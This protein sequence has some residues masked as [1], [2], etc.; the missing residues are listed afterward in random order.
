MGRSLWAVGCGQWAVGVKSRLLLLVCRVCRL[1]QLFL[2]DMGRVGDFD[3]AS[4]GRV[5]SVAGDFV[6]ERHCGDRNEKRLILRV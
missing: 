6:A 4:P 5:N 2:A 3:M 1:C